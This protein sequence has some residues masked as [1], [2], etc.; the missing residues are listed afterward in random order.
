MSDNIDAQKIILAHS[1]TYSEIRQEPWN[2]VDDTGQPAFE[3]SWANHG[4]GNESCRFK[5]DELG[6]TV[7]E[8][9]VAGGTSNTTIF[10]L[11]Q[12]Y[13]PQ[14]HHIFAIE[15]NSAAHGYAQ[16]LNTGVVRAVATSTTYVSLDGVRFSID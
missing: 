9:V 14:G 16:V 7:I 15:T 13:R 2:Y 3:N 10:T 6:F 8:G 12:A 4:S 1:I 5:L 11:P